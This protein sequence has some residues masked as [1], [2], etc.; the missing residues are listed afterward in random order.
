MRVI[1]LL[2]KDYKHS[3]MSGIFDY[4]KE[5]RFMYWKRRLEGNWYFSD[6]AYYR[7]AR[8]ILKDTT[9]NRRKWNLILSPS[10]YVMYGDAPLTVASLVT[11]EGHYSLAHDGKLTFYEEG[12]GGETITKTARIC[13]L[14]GKELVYCYDKDQFQNLNYINEQKRMATADRVYYSFFRL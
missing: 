2:L 10:S 8:R 7:D 14:N 12:A 6:A 13:K 5:L 1:L 11:K 3:D 9:V 4:M